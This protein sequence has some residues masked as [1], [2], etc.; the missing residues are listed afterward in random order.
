MNLLHPV[1]QGCMFYLVYK[2]L[3]TLSNFEWRKAKKHESQISC[4]IPLSMNRGVNLA[5]GCHSSTYEI[6]Y[7]FMIT[8]QQCED[9]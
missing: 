5:G 2:K 4:T 8:Y 1:K 3:S 6:Y 7:L 9:R